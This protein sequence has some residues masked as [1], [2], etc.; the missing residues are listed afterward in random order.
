[1]KRHIPNSITLFNLFCGC[2]A[3]VSIL[4]YQF[5]TAF[6]LVFICVVADFFDGLVARWLRVKSTLGKEL[7]SI[8]DM[9]SFGVVP[10]AIFF[11]LLTE[12]FDLGPGQLSLLA[13]PGF[14][15]SAF[16]GLRLARFNLDTRQAEGFIGLPTPSLTI[17]AVGLML[18]FKD[19]LY[20]WNSWLLHPAVLYSLIGLFSYLL[21]AEFPMFSFKF[22]HFRWKGNEIKFIFIAIILVEIVLFRGAAF[23]LIILTYLLLALVDLLIKRSKSPV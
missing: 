12:S 6:W 16:A 22:T 14:L 9:V 7:D 13:I 23:A 2:L 18:I 4:Y 17:F 21:N 3:V 20:G 8:A 10:G 15:V 5:N 11:I 1:M 19:N